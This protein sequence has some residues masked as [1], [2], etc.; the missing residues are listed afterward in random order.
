MTRPGSWNQNVLV[1]SIIVDDA[2]DT[3]PRVVNIVKVAPKVAY[4]AN[5]SV[6]GLMN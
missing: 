4:L 2:G 5:V 3:V 6:V 1:V